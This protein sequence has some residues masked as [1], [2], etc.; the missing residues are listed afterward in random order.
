MILKNKVPF[1]RVLQPN[2][3]RPY[4]IQPPL[5]FITITLWNRHFHYLITK[6]SQYPTPQCSR[7]NRKNMFNF[8]S[9]KCKNRIT[10]IHIHLS[11]CMYMYAS[12]ICT[13]FFLLSFFLYCRY[14]RWEK[15]IEEESFFLFV[16]SLW[17]GW[18]VLL[19]VKRDTD[20]ATAYLRKKLGRQNDLIVKMTLLPFFIFNNKSGIFELCPFSPLKVNCKIASLVPNLWF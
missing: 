7:K 6:N 8:N 5:H 20:W 10:Y 18:L 1:S 4:Q 11:A 14:C 15:G 19:S 2:T 3:V 17:P 9:I 16:F 13:D 12:R